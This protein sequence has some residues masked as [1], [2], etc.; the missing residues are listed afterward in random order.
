MERLKRLFSTP[1][2]LGVYLLKDAVVIWGHSLFAPLNPLVA[3]SFSSLAYLYY[4]AHATSTTLS[5]VDKFEAQATVGTRRYVLSRIG[6]GENHLLVGI[7]VSPHHPICKSLQRYLR[8]I[9]RSYRRAMS[10]SLDT[11]D[12]DQVRSSLRRATSRD[13]AM[14]SHS[15]I[16]QE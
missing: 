5:P 7:L 2:I 13:S 8:Q 10:L 16:S 4:D 9:D 15:D 1:G 6:E 11:A 12:L 3:R 14:D